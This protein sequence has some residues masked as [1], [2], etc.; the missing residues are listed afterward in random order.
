[1]QVADEEELVAIIYFG[2]FNNYYL[3]LQRKYHDAQ[4]SPNRCEQS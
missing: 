1:L 3:S 4:A 2:P